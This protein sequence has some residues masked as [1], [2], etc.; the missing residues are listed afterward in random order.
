M[1]SKARLTKVVYFESQSLLELGFF[2]VIIRFAEEE[3]ILTTRGRY[4]VMAIVELALRSEEDKPCRLASIAASQKIDLSYL[5]QIF[6]AL[7]NANLVAS[8]RGPHGGYR[9]AKRADEIK[10]I[11]VI[12]AVNEPLKMTRCSKGKSCVGDARCRTHWLWSGLTR[13]IE[14]YLDS[15]TLEDVLA[16]DSDK[17]LENN[18]SLSINK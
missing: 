14:G 16:G 6:N 12:R 11:E 17:N 9:L 2:E 15:L 5:E 7:K 13:R 18:F 1:L 10:V 4:A 8:F 3:M